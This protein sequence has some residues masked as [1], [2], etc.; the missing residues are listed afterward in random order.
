MT[1]K[2]T[3]NDINDTECKDAQR[4]SQETVYVR[5]KHIFSE[6]LSGEKSLTQDLKQPC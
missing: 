1:L 6:S 3:N 4:H 5:F 2:I